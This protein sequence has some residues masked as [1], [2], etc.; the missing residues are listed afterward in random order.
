MI[1]YFSGTG[2]SRYCAE[3]LA[4][5]LEDEIVDSFQYIRNQ[6]SADLISG[7]PW[8][9][10][11]PT[12][13]WQIPHIFADFLRSASFEGSNDA[14]FVLS[15]GSNIGNASSVNEKI[16]QEKGLNYC[17]TVDIMMPENYIAMFNVPSEKKIRELMKLAGLKLQSVAEKIAAGQKLKSRH[18]GII[19]RIQTGTINPI[20]YQQIISASR[21]TVSDAC[22]GC[23]KCEQQCPLNNIHLENGKPVWADQCTHCMKCICGCPQQAVE[24]G[25]S[26]LGKPRYQCA[27]YVR[28]EEKALS[29]K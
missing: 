17:G 27:A 13:G 23:G 9:F 28:K 4:D 2:N 29:G 8:I 24:Y 15:C 22:N 6:I 18:G 5:L 20:F 12:Y 11:S 14:Y 3:M 10:V 26:S 1:V 21:F 25:T 19:G 16:C 7:K